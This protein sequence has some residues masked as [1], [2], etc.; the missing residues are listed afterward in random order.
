MTKHCEFGGSG[1]KRWL[2]CP[3]SITMSRGIKRESSP[4][5]EEGTKAHALGEWC[6]KHGK[7]IAEAPE[8]MRMDEESEAAVQ[9][10]LD[11][12]RPSFGDRHW[13]EA[14]V[15]LLP[16]LSEPLVDQLFGT[17]DFA[18]VKGN[19]LLIADYKHGKGVPVP[20]EGNDQMLFYAAGMMA[21]LREKEP[22]RAIRKITLAVIQPRCSD[23]DPVQSVEIVPETIYRWIKMRLEPGIRAALLSAP[24]F[25]P[26]ADNCRFC[27]AHG[28][29][30][31]AEARRWMRCS[32]P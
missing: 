4:Y 29:C 12:A 19:H 23:V 21:L 14:S 17:V 27:P 32:H 1:A 9:I 15:D 24:T 8:A 18:S 2:T 20:L 6:L 31:A 16:M 10:Y 25:A 30:K 13:I 28:K 5:A 22:G 26:S 7:Q 11:K 3:A